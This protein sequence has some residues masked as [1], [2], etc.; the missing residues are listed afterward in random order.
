MKKFKLI[1]T[2]V[3]SLMFGG[4]AAQTF[5]GGYV[6]PEGEEKFRLEAPMYGPG[7]EPKIELQPKPRPVQIDTRPVP[8]RVKPVIARNTEEIKLLT[9]FNTCL[10]KAKD[11]EELEECYDGHAEK[12]AELGSRFEAMAKKEMDAMK[13]ASNPAA[14][15]GPAKKDSK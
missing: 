9:K 2:L 13:K 7:Q 3:A 6:P 4:A 11:D 1:S 14:S 10:A 15:K 12:M 5:L 8:I